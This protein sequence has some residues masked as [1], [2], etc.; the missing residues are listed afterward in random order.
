MTASINLFFALLPPP[1]LRPALVQLGAVLRSAHGLRGASIGADRLHLTL[2]S[3]L[4]ERRPL[5][6]CIAAAK[7]VGDQISHAAIP[8]LFEWT[9]SFYTRPGACPLVLRGAQGLDQVCAFRRLLRAQMQK[10]GLAMDA[11]FTPHIT[12]LW[13]DRVVG[14]HPIAPIHWQADELVLVKSLVGQSRH[15]HVARWPLQ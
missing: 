12:L 15:V 1:A 3:C 7:A 10:S 13:A 6:D 5:D 11:S 4:D 14:A 8:L 9:D 2:A